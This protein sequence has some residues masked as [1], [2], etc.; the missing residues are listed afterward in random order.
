MKTFGIDFDGTYAAE[1]DTFR[2]VVDLLQQAGHQC[3]IV[4]NR[5]QAES[6][7]VARVVAGQMPIICTGGRPKRQAAIDAGYRVAIWVD[8]MPVLVDFGEAGLI[9]TGDRY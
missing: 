6:A 7:Q 3:I 2:A 5:P 9:M 8:D 1:V 4:T